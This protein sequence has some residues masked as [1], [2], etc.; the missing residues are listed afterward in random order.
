VSAEVLAATERLLVRGERFASLSVQRICD[1][2]GVARSAFYV[3]FDDKTDLLLRLVAASME[4]IA[5]IA[6]GWIHSRPT[7]SHDALVAAQERAVAVY[8]EHDALLRASAES[9]AYDD[10]VA[11]V[12]RGRLDGVVTTFAERLRVAQRRGEVRGDIDAEAAAR[13]IV[14]GVEQVLRDHVERGVASADRALASHLAQLVW[15]MLGPP[16]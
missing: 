2:A 8:R 7:L 12:W 13:L 3:N 5:E 15:L 6:A 11:E 10:R 4:D 16:S 1:E 14:F 9:A